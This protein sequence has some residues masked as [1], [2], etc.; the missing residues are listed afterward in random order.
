MR[1]CLLEDFAEEIY[2]DELIRKYMC[3]YVW[4]SGSSTKV[5]PIQIWGERREVELQIDTKKNVFNKLIERYKEKYNEI[6]YAYFDKTDDSCPSR[7][8]FKFFGE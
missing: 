8:V 6:E 7:L 3:K 5:F 1:K 2:N 4:L